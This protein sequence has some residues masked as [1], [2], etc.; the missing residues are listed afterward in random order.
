MP[1]YGGRPP[2]GRGSGSRA[3]RESMREW[4]RQQQ[5]QWEEERRF[6]ELDTDS[7]D[8]L[9]A[10][11]S[12]SFASDELHFT[13]ADLGRSDHRRQK[14]TYSDESEHSDDVE[15]D[16][17][18]A[19]NMQ[20]ALREK[21]DVL[22]ERALARI[23]RAQELGR[24]DVQLTP[25][26]KEA[27]ERKMQKDQQT[28][29]TKRPLLKGKKSSE[30]SRRTSS[31]NSSRTNLAVVPAASSKR[32]GGRTSLSRSEEAPP[33]RNEAPPP[34]PPGFMVPD[35]RGHPV[36]YPLGYPPSHT[37]PLSSSSSRPASHSHSSPPRPL[38]HRPPGPEADPYHG[39]ASP[40]DE[41]AW[42][43]SPRSR[44]APGWSSNPPYP[45]GYPPPQPPYAYA[46]GPSAPAG[47]RY[48]SG[49]AELGSA[50]DPRRYYAPPGGAPRRA[51]R[52]DGAYGPRWESESDE[53]EDEDEGD[54]GVPVE[55]RPTTERYEGAPGRS[56][57]AGGASGSG[58]GRQRRVR[59][60]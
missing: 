55:A 52:S 11:P 19:G 20:V 51:R 59:G 35:A 28:K 31:R 22:V 15:N 30:D 57:G 41:G 10:G 21:E 56:S 33:P 44:P 5:R 32:K 27:L 46:A 1:P 6:E 54:Q 23:R 50:P 9:D 45:V 3:W 24:N 47:R 13:G 53:D 43:P 39:Y 58:S 48:V 60:R 34:M 18:G 29:R 42:Y 17:E 26:E 8:G 38:S 37:P 12:R 14:Y 49:P 7:E 16:D 4:E 2:G 36:H 40:H 25:P